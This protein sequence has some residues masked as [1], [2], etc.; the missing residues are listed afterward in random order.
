MKYVHAPNGIF[1]ATILPGEVYE[2]SDRCKTTAKSLTAKE[3]AEYGVSKLKLTTPP[4]FDPTTQGRH[5][6]IPALV[7]GV[8]TQQWEVYALNPGE[9]AQAVARL[10]QDIVDAT[11]QRLDNFAKTR[12]YDGIV[13]LCTY[14]TSPTAKFQAEGQYGVEARDAT[15]AKLYEILAE[16]EAGTRPVP[17][18]YQD[19]EPDLPPLQWPA[20]PE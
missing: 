12:G 18:G 15:W 8:W 11:Q 6:V 20:Q 7:D 2:F 5:E 19:I 4:Y 17:S 1:K 14:A 9:A 16:V 10:Q 13:S 3:I